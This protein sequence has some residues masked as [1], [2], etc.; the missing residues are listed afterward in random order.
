MKTLKSFY[1]LGGQ[2][3]SHLFTRRS[4][5][6]DQRT[7]VTAVARLLAKMAAPQPRT[8]LAM[9]ETEHM[10]GDGV[11]RHALCYTCLLYTSDAADD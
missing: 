4:D 10:A 11:K 8:T 7:A 3:C 2:P 1:N 6:A 5:L 9:I